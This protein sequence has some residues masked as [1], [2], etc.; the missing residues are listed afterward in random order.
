MLPGLVSS[1]SDLVAEL[2]GQAFP[3]EDPERGPRPRWPTTSST[4]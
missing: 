2:L 3:P 4:R 1:D